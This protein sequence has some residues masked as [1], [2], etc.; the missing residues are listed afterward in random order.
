M[1]PRTHTQT[2]FSAQLWSGNSVD[3]FWRAAR[4]KSGRWG[5]EMRG[6][7]LQFSSTR[8]KARQT[9]LQRWG[10]RCS[11]PAWHRG[12]GRSLKYHR[13]KTRNKSSDD[14]DCAFTKSINH[15]VLQIKWQ[16]MIQQY[17]LIIK[18]LNMKVS[19]QHY[20]TWFNPTVSIKK[21][22]SH[23]VGSYLIK[24]IFYLIGC[25]ETFSFGLNSKPNPQQS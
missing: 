1:H 24:L 13:I 6:G 9:S 2:H 3:S 18:A 5:D 16:Y 23:Q 25:F 21:Q 19:R 15:P 11:S 8:N 7:G 14:G 17:C 4:R 12:T 20:L 22:Q 10:G